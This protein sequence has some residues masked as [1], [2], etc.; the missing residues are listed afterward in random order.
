[1]LDL[2]LYAL[3]AVAA[4]E[5]PALLEPSKQWVVNFAEQQ[6]VASRSHSDGKGEIALALRQSP[7]DDIIHLFVIRDGHASKWANQVP[8]RL[9]IGDGATTKTFALRYSAG[10]EGP[11]RRV[12]RVTI[13]AEQRPQLAAAKS[14]EVSAEGGPRTAFRLS[15]MDSISKLLNDCTHDLRKFWNMG[16]AATVVAVPAKPVQELATLF[17]WTDYPGAA[18]TKQQEGAAQLMLLINETGAIDSCQV[19]RTEGAPLFETMGCQ[20]LLQRAKFEPA[21]DL[22]GKPVRS[23]YISPPIRFSL[24]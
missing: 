7:Y 10:R 13:P 18:L 21:R 11:A 14:V 17:S 6:C 19:V 1:M 16:E 2:S 22:R 9:T 15:K 23:S 12:D 8:A 20:V 24:R 3:L 4:P 5:P